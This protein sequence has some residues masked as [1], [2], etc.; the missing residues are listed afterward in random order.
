M[1]KIMIDRAL[2]E[3]ALGALDVA[4][5]CIDVYYVPRGKTMPEIEKAQNAFRAAMAQQQAGS[6]QDGVLEGHLRERERWLAQEQAEPK[7][8]GRLPPPL[9]AEPVAWRCACGAN[10]YIDAQGR[11][12]SKAEPVEP[13]AWYQKRGQEVLTSHPACWGREDEPWT[14]LYTAPPQRKP[15][16]DEEIDV[17]TA[18]ER[19]AL[20]DHIY[21]YGTAAEGVLERIR[22]L[23][24]AAAEIGRRM[25]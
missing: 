24:R 15:L 8:G 22:K 12:A 17:A 19:D 2:V 14:P 7:G 16:T 20:L 21:E 23:C 10:L 9:Q 5:A 11:P 3:Q 25:K 4:A 6:W 1:S 18:Q 13:V